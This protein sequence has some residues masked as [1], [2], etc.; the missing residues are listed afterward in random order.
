MIGKK[1]LLA[2]I[3]AGLL[4]GCAGTP[5]PTAS[6]QPPTTPQSSEQ[7]LYSSSPERPGWTMEEPD[8]VNGVMTFVG[9]SNRYATEKGSREDARRNATSGVV[10]YMGI[11]VK[12]KFEQASVNYGL[13][14]SV[15][16][17]TT[18]ARQF[19]KQ[20]AVNMARKVKVKKWYMEKW[21]TPTGIGYQTFAMTNVPMQ[22]IDE[23]FK[24]TAKDMQKKAEQKAKE[25]A[26]VI[27]KKQTEKA[28]EFWKQMQDQGLVE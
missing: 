19:E 12:D 7:L 9:V 10:K 24:A 6:V 1:A 11:L 15:I 8:T 16:D 23:S 25:E 2:M 3:S 20:L 17:P 28:A 18:S 4:W 5:A 22:A 14:S 26:D 13:D 27:A 21:Q